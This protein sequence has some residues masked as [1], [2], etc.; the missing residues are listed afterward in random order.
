LQLRRDPALSKRLATGAVA[1]AREHF[2]WR[3][4]AGALAAFYEKISD[5]TKEK[6]DAATVSA[7]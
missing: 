1:F 7:S 4:N 6:N 3:R 2:D 5:C